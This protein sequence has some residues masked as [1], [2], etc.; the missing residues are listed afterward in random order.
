M[1]VGT[2]V[3][4]KRRMHV[5][6]L[7]MKIRIE[8]GNWLPVLVA[9]IFILGTGATAE[10]QTYPGNGECHCLKRFYSTTTRLKPEL[11]AMRP[12]SFYGTYIKSG[13]S[14]YGYDAAS[15]TYKTQMVGVM[16]TEASGVCTQAGNAAC[17][18]LCA[19]YHSR[20]YFVAHGMR[21]E[22]CE[23]EPP[24]STES[25][26]TARY[27]KCGST[28][29]LNKMRFTVLS[30]YPYRLFSCSYK[31]PVSP[32][33]RCKTEEGAVKPQIVELAAERSNPKQTHQ[34]VC[35]RYR[36]WTTRTWWQCRNDCFRKQQNAREDVY[37]N[38]SRFASSY[39]ADAQALFPTTCNA[40]PAELTASQTDPAAIEQI[41][42][43]GNVTATP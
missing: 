28:S 24:G 39:N 38:C 10:A 22:L 33:S 20:Y 2:F 14:F 42:S 7:Q 6:R 40:V 8:S 16:D 19:S 30:S 13:Q 11:E 17:E 36:D 5:E 26:R 18:A 43:N 4:R 37:L 9:S 41:D 1:T 3:R 29:T 27:Y 12:S 34:F 23:T 25:L 32:S 31:Y 15:Q 35:N 21:N